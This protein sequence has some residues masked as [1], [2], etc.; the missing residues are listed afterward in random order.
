MAAAM[1][2]CAQDRARA[3]DQQTTPSLA[4]SADT[5]NQRWEQVQW[6]KSRVPETGCDSPKFG[7]AVGM[8]STGFGIA[9][10]GTGNGPCRKS[11]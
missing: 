7:I 4:Y 10:S 1:P 8:M 6:G 9:I 3:S 2:S 5:L 11:S